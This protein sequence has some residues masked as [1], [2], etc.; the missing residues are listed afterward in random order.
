MGFL[1]RLFRKSKTE[2]ELPPKAVVSPSNVVEQPSIKQPPKSK[3][4][5]CTIQGIRPHEDVL[6][7]LWFA[8]SPLKNI[9]AEKTAILDE[10]EYMGT[11]ITFYGQPEPSAIY[12]G[13]PIR[14]STE[15]TERP[16]YYPSYRSLTPEQRYEYLKFL[17]NPYGTNNVGYAFIFYYGLERHLICGDFDKAFEMILKLRDVYD[18]HSFQS[19]SANALVLISII[20]DRPDKIELFLGSIDKSFEYAME[21]NIYLLAKHC[22]GIGLTARDIIYY[23]SAFGFT[24]KRYIKSQ[25][26]L[27]EQCVVESMQ[28]TLKGDT[29]TIPKLSPSK[30]AVELFANMSL[31]GSVLSI[32]DYFSAKDFLG[33]GYHILYAAHERCKSILADARKKKTTE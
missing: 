3:E 8:D 32:P 29:L 27:F 1:S 33:K 15:P 19:Y 25:P 7:L 10:F 13:L 18:N 5:A 6:P 4:L 2:Q 28:Q 14:P 20:R 26:A 12:A 24:N 16:P 9:D 21:P 17:S 22:L 11:N 31:H 30:S 23:S